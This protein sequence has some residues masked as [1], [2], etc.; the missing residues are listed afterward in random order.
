MFLISFK[1]IAPPKQLDLI[2][3]DHMAW[4]VGGFE[5]GIFI[6]GGRLVP[7]TGGVILAVHDRKAVSDLIDREPFSRQ[8]LA[9]IELQE[10]E[11]MS[12]A[13]GL[14]RLKHGQAT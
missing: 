8:G 12:T 4:A 3:P 5:A 10:I 9:E 2:R 14:E 13:P 1:P 11:V 7:P 6:A